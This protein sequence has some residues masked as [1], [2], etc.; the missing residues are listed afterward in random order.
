MS[1]VELEPSAADTSACATPIYG[2]V[3]GVLIGFKNEGT[4][5]LVQFGSRPTAVAARSIVDLHGAHIGHSV[6]LSF[7]GGD[8]RRPIIMGRV[9]Q[10][11]DRAAPA[12]LGQ[13]ELEAD[14]ERMIV[15]ARDQLVL[16][17]GKARI[18]LTS[19]GKVIIE[20]TYVSS[21]SSGVNRIHGGSIQLN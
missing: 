11:G 13:V 7:D 14:G 3:T 8:P 5:P 2:V 21:R 12:G 1:A 15:S 20:G 6:V 19:T 4:V 9:V 17:C 16:R 18:T 10:D